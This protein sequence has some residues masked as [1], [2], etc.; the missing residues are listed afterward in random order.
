MLQERIAKGI[1]AVA[2]CAIR[3]KAE[4]TLPGRLVMSAPVASLTPVIIQTS[5][6]DLGVS[7]NGLEFVRIQLI[8]YSLH[9]SDPA[10]RLF[11]A[12]HVENVEFGSTYSHVAASP[13]APHL[14]R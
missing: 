13:N 8:N 2:R 10:C 7:H 14:C 5:K 11:S 3:L 4:Q 6:A 1:V 12:T 9:Q